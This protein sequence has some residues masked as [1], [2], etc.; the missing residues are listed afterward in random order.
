MAR[1]KDYHNFLVTPFK[2]GVKGFT[3][4]AEYFMLYAPNL[5]SA[6]S[7]GKIEGEIAEQVF[8]EM[9]KRTDMKNSYKII[10]NLTDASWKKY[11]L[12]NDI[13]DFEQ[14]RFICKKLKNESD[15]QCL[16]RH[17]RNSLAHG[18]VYIWKKRDKHNNIN[19]VFFVDYDSTRK[20]NKISAKIMVST[21]ILDTWKAVLENQI[22]IGE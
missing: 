18:Y 2:S 4:L 3:T 22:A 12:S 20:I 14:S 8:N 17:I 21:T 16:L 1:K 9:I 5:D 13:L 15:L 7:R 6:H 10:K 11:D 19:Y